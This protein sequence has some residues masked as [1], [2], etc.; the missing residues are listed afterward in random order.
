MLKTNLGSIRFF[1]YKNWTALYTYEEGG[2]QTFYSFSWDL[3]LNAN[4]YIEIYGYDWG[5]FNVYNWW[6]F[7]SIRKVD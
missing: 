7:L 6:T 2:N 3:D 5:V 4:D 1:L